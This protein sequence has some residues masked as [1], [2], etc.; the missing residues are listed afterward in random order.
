MG[1]GRVSREARGESLKGWGV[2][3]N[4]PS[5]AEHF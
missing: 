3:G 1:K 4:C 2:W 5:D